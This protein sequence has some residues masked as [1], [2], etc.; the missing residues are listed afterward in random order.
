MK[1]GFAGIGRMGEP[2][3]FRLL[4]ANFPLN[5]WNRTQEKL[6]ALTAAGARAAVTLRELATESDV[7]LTMV[8]DDAAV[9]SI[10][11]GS[12]GL[13]S[14]P[15]KGKIFADMSTILPATVSRIAAAVTEH[16]ASFADAPVAGTV[17]PAREGRLL[18]FA[19]GSAEDVERLKPVFNV[20]ARRIDHLGPVGSG[21]AMKLVHNALLSTYWAV[22][23]EAMAMGTRYG[24]DLKRMLDVISESPAN[25]AALGMKTPLLLGQSSEVAFNIANV[26][27]DLNAIV[28]FSESTGVPIPVVQAALEKYERAISQGHAQEDVAGIVPL[29]FR[30]FRERE[31]RSGG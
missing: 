6:S 24:L 17:Q 25:F 11:L 12:D 4:N 19:G 10:Y 15:V 14:V 13:L 28:K 2:M 21:A 5:V 29:S 30:A 9:E 8:T 20:L 18:I 3:A 23:A 22:F 7:V 27:K 26:R 31:P 1:I 16:A